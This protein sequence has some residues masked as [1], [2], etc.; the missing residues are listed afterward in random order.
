MAR[1]AK[2]RKR[3]WAGLDPKV[4]KEILADLISQPDIIAAEKC[5]SA[6]LQLNYRRAKFRIDSLPPSIARKIPALVIKVRE[7][8]QVPF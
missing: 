8:S 2:G 3:D 6:C 1:D 5:G 4:V 7:L